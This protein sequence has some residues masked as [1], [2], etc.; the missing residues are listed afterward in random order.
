MREHTEL[1]S[2]VM[3]IWIAL[4]ILSFWFFNFSKNVKLKKR[5]LPIFIV[6][7]G[8]LFTG[9]VLLMTGEPKVVLITIPA[10]VIIS[11]LNLRMIKFCESCGRTLYNRMWF[12][13]MEYCSK[14]GAK[15]R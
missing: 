4:G 2:W 6:G 9:V 13:K 11:L 12:S 14:C 3:G 15:L 8:V 7:A 10:V 1:F 5:L